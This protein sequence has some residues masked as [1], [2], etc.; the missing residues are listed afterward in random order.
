MGSESKHFAHRDNLSKT[1]RQKGR[2]MQE[3][4][5]K[6]D[7]KN[8]KSRRESYAL[9]VTAGSGNTLPEFKLWHYALIDA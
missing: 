2:K 3:I 8:L 7:T 4:E 1:Q 9:S 5:R 6:E